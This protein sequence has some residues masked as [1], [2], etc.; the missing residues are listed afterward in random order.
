MQPNTATTVWNF[1]ERKTKKRGKVKRQVEVIFKLSSRL[2]VVVYAGGPL[3]SPTLFPFIITLSLLFLFFP[4]NISNSIIV[5]S[6][7]L[8]L[9]IFY[10]HSSL[11]PPSHPYFTP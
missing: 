6:F 1:P 4:K 7:F 11:L 2:Y 10:I 8:P 3:L 5:L 9:Y